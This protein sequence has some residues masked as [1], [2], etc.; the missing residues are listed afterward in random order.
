MGLGGLRPSLAEVGGRRRPG[1]PRCRARRS[2]VLRL[3]GPSLRPRRRE[4]GTGPAVGL[5]GDGTRHRSSARQKEAA[6]LVA[7]G[8]GGAGLQVCG[9]KVSGCPLRSDTR[10]R[11]R[12]ALRVDRP[13]EPGGLSAFATANTKRPRM[14]ALCSLCSASVVSR[15]RFCRA[16]V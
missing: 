2:A 10:R 6:R 1:G 9:W 15:R 13:E 3:A 11:G 7:A 8:P 12:G 4:V 5:R 16:V 14:A